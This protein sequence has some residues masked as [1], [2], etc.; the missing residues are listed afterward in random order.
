M[1]IISTELNGVPFITNVFYKN[2]KVILRFLHF[3]QQ[4]VR[5]RITNMI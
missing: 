4:L 5:D 2:A 3:N 1:K